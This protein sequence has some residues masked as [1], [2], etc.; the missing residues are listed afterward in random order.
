M[1][2]ERDQSG[3]SSFVGDQGIPSF[4]DGGSSKIR[5]KVVILD[6]EKMDREF[7]TDLDLD[8]SDGVGT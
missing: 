8:E 6:G 3:G 2:D 5:S 7:F 1:N 4:V